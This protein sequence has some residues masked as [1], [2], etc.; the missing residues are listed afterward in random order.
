MAGK[1]KNCFL[2]NA[3]AGSGKT[4]KIKSMIKSFLEEDKK[5]NILCITYTNRAADELAEEFDT[6]R[7]YVGTIHSFLHSFM[8]N[9]FKHK[10]ILKLY[11]D[12]FGKSILERITNVENKK[13]IEE[14]NQ[15]YIEKYGQLNFDVIKENIKCISY[16]ESQ[17]STLYYGG[18]SHD[19]LI[20]FSKYVFDNCPIMLKR[21]SSKYQYI[22]IDEYQDT[23]AEV[24]KIFFES[25]K[26]SSSELYL[27]G[28]RMQQIYK[29]Y[30]GSFEEQFNLFDDTQLLSTNY[31]S[32]GEIVSILNKIY[33]DKCFIQK[34]SESMKE[35]RP[36]FCPRVVISNNVESYIRNIK[37]EN[38]D[39]LVLYILN[40]E[41]FKDIGVSNLYQAFSNMKKYSFGRTYTPVDVLTIS[42]NDNPDSFLKLLYCVTE[43]EEHFRKQQYGVIVKILKSNK[44]MFSKEACCIQ[45][46][47]DKERLFDNLKKIFCV[48][49]DTNKTISD[50]ID[51][52]K[53]TSFLEESYIN[54]V[55]S[56]EDNAQVLD[57]PAIEL[58]RIV[59]YLDSPK[60][61]TQHGVKGES[62]D[63]VLFVADDSM[64]SPLVHMYSF[65]EI[66]G[67]LQV[68][69]KSFNEF[70]YAYRKEII[71][72]QNKIGMKTNELK[73][74]SYLVNKNCIENKLKEIKSEFYGSPYFSFLY[75]EIYDK[76]FSKP[77]VTAAKDC[78]KDSTIFGV[79]SAY[80]L[81]YVGCSRARRNLTILLDRSKIKG[82]LS[83]LKAK[84]I[85][86]GFKVEE[87]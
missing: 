18:L 81:F 55:L 14:S 87:V 76:Y 32:V 78:L 12:F 86:I 59:E 46:H 25:V 50:L 15:K 9:Y 48:F 66:W 62:H 39:T 67:S 69:L 26:E 35:V 27:F 60:V 22:F 24:L 2:V 80:K 40:K 23:M 51:I 41:R 30:D 77:G 10:D 68:S 16:N 36:D 83:I 43:M 13:N 57:V 5:N 33:N 8:K 72:L 56:D 38:P 71:D 53:S 54:E 17:F 47:S 65:F 44:S 75:E 73:K 7:L 64:N 49:E 85:E 28:D 45:K 58:K 21:L 4:T 70:Y 6:Q 37:L 20:A 63:S 42:Y 11:F 79:L 84:F 61:S 1:I 34:V 29:N 74:E 52:L 82:D 3:A 19:D 31:R